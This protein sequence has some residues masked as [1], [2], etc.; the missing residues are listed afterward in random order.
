MKNLKVMVASLIA[1]T[2]LLQGIPAMADPK[3]GKENP[4]LHKGWEKKHHGWAKGHEKWHDGDDER[5]DYHYRSD[6]SHDDR[7]Y[8]RSGEIHRDSKDLRTGRTAIQTKNKTTATVKTDRVQPSQDAKSGAAGKITQNGGEV[9]D[10]IGRTRTATQTKNKTG[11]A[12]KSDR[13]QSSQLAKSGAA[14][15]I[16]QSGGEILDGIGRSRR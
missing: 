4:G 9:L 1:G 12:V 7:D 10:G 2:L 11:A 16:T 13:A 6:A 14:G 15:K 3:E 5:G 8:R